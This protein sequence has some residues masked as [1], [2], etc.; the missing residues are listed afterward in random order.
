MGVSQ[1]SG[2]R[3]ILVIGSPGAGKSTLARALGDR[4]HVPVTHLDAEHWLPGWTVPPKAGW[5]RRVDELISSD[6]WIID[7]NYGGTLGRRLM[8]AEAVVFTD[9]P[10][11][12]C[13]WRVWK[14]ALRWVGRQRVDMAPGCP[15]H[16]PDLAVMGFIWGYPTHSRPRILALLKEA[17]AVVVHLRSPRAL[18]TW[19]TR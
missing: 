13:L 5:E 18:S 10:R 8:R 1:L 7:G 15:E 3:R 6:A 4:L 2:L 9:F 14:R 19:M 12:R 17:N 11:V 16:L